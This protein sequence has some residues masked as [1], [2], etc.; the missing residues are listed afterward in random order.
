[1]GLFGLI[2]RQEAIRRMDLWGG[3]GKPFFFLVSFDGEQC[4]VCP[5]ESLP[6]D[7]LLFNYN[8]VTNEEPPLKVADYSSQPVEWQIFPES[9][10][11]YCASFDVV[12]RNLLAGNSF[13][14]NLTCRTPLLTN[15]TL[16]DIYARSRAKY[17]LWWEGH[18]T[19][20]SPEI[21]VQIGE[22]CIRTFPMKGTVEA[23]RPDAEQRLLADEKE[24]AEHA[25]ITDLLR[26]DLSQ[27][28]DHVRVER[29]RYI[30]RLATHKGTLLQT[31]SEITGRLPREFFRQLGEAFF[32]LLPAG[33]VTG[34]PKK[35][36]V[37]IIREAE[38]Y[39]RGFYTGVTGFFDG[40]NLDSAVLIRFVE[41]GADGRLYFKSGGGI[42]FRSDCRREYEEM[43]EKIYVPIY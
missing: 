28:A 41:E 32:R 8:G 20:F 13:L 31:S 3:A 21:F 24:A 34:A 38:T 35:K 4:V 6:A 43:I 18:F 40:K 27:V 22:E 19:V 29:Y 16:R 15:L 39:E 7:K 2:D 23:D 12:R 30:D 5:P 42:T 10:E 36:T 9:Y 17:R 14:L 25:T 26:N 33:S 1:M 37:E 11:Q